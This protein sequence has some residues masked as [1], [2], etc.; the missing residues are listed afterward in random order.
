MK[1]CRMTLYVLI[2]KLKFDSSYDFEHE[3]EDEACFMEYRYDESFT[4]MRCISYH[5]FNNCH[6]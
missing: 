4:S 1:N 2:G 3:G 5:A 6:R